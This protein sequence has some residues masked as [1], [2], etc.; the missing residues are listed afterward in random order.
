MAFF[1]VKFRDTETGEVLKGTVEVTGDVA[2]KILDLRVEAN[3]L[4]LQA[5]KSAIEDGGHANRVV[6][7]YGTLPYPASPWVGPHGE[8]PAFCSTPD[9]CK[10]RSSCPRSRAC[11]E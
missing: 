10:G 4:E 6:W 2:D 8:C 5:I 3:N 1:W 11:S 9:H 7:E